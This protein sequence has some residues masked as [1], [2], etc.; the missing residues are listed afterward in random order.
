MDLA[1]ELLHDNYGSLR[2]RVLLAKTDIVDTGLRCQVSNEI[3]RRLV[4][5]VL[6]R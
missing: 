2:F 3:T 4:R 6:E 5:H 1:D